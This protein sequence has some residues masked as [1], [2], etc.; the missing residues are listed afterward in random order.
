M[1]RFLFRISKSKHAQSVVRKGAPMLNAIGI[2]SARPTL[3]IDIL[4]KGDE[5]F[6]AS[7]R[8]TPIYSVPRK[9][10]TISGSIGS[11]AIA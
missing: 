1:E 2:P 7:P 4:R 6:A 9:R 8:P 11:T 10:S 3:D 5:R